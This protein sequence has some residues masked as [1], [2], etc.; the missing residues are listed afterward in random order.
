MLLTLA[1]SMLSV[2][3]TDNIYGFIKISQ[4]L[5]EDG[6]GKSIKI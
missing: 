6:A 2:K 5:R 3:K 1:P 4:C